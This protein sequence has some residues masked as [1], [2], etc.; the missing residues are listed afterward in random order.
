MLSRSSHDDPQAASW[1]YVL[2][3]TRQAPRNVEDWPLV[4]SC[5][6]L[7]PDSGSAHSSVV[8]WL[9]Q[10]AST[11][12]LGHQFSAVH[13]LKP[14]GGARKLMGVPPLDMTTRPFSV[15]RTTSGPAGLSVKPWDPLPAPGNE[16]GEHSCRAPVRLYRCRGR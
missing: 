12:W 4:L 14:C 5:V 3:A 16:S 11:D 15:S 10:V 8:D 13:E 6:G 9:E 1:A 7:A 2:P